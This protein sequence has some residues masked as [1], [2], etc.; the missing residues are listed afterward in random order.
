MLNYY[1]IIWSLNNKCTGNLKV[2]PQFV[3]C[4][5][6]ILFSKQFSLISVICT[7]HICISICNNLAPNKFMLTK[8][9]RR[10]NKK[11]IT[12][13][14]YTISDT[15]PHSISHTF[16]HLDSWLLILYSTN[17]LILHAL[18]QNFKNDVL[19]VRKLG[20]YCSNRQ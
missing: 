5:N 9:L 1:V 3:F 6:H 12:I 10:K 2:S 16:R 4:A 7:L 8:N 18:H 14:Y 15:H 20:V 13:D 11:K 19:G 17:A